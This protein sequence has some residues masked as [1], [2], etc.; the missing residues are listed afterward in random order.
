MRKVTGMA[1]PLRLC[2]EGGFYHVFHR[3][4]ERREIFGVRREREHFLDLL[5]EITE[6]FGVEVHAYCLMDNHYHA[7]LGTPR[8]NL[9][10]AMHW[11]NMAY[12]VWLN[13]RRERVGPVFAGRF[14]SVPV[15]AC[16]LCA[17][18]QYI[19]LNPVRTEAFGWDKRVRAQE[20]A[21]SAQGAAPDVLRA[22]VKA[23]RAYGWSSYR[24]YAGYA[25]KPD[26][27]EDGKAAGGHGPL[28][29]RRNTEKA[30]LSGGEE[31]LWER[32]RQT[33]AVGS[34][35]FAERVRLAAKGN[36]RR[37]WT[38]RRKLVRLADWSAVVK[39]VER[40]CGMKWGAL[41]D[42]HGNGGRE[43]AFWLGRR[44]CGLSLRELGARA[45]GVD[46]AAVSVALKR[47]EHRMSEDADIRERRQRLENELS[48]LARR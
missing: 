14:G 35:A 31:S 29:Y 34:E 8:G 16:A 47:F 22:R 36:V 41:R 5:G 13:K 27:L 28:A 1:R 15:E 44:L 25:P 3:G 23:L 9:S 32:F 48:D 30:V 4:L 24:A 42:A 37:E 6:L 21:G 11:L 38:G 18:T 26:W 46:Y 10:A 40:E 33:V 7:L 20:R 2:G 17:V 45:G 39:A 43:L 19:H 12:S